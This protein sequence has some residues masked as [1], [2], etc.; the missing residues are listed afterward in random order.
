MVPL[1][2]SWGVGQQELI[3]THRLAMPRVV[4]IVDTNLYRGMSDPRTCH[5]HSQW[6]HRR[7]SRRSLSAKPKMP[8]LNAIYGTAQS[9]RVGDLVFIHGLDGDAISTWQV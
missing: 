1:R 3:R 4:A 7:L 2:L 6:K 9:D 8:Q 5:T